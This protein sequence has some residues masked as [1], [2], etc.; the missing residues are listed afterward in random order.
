MQIGMFTL[1]ASKGK[2]QQVMVGCKFSATLACLHGESRRLCLFALTRTRAPALLAGM[3][4]R[5]FSQ[6]IVAHSR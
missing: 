3:Y 6:V 2:S 5:H 1:C 4:D